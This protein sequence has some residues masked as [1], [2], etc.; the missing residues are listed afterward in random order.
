MP[1]KVT[2]PDM[3]LYDERIN[4]FVNIKGGSF[5]IEH[6]L[7]SISKWESIWHKPFFSV[8]K[9]DKKSTEELRSYIECM[10]LT[11]NVDQ[12]LYKYIPSSELDRIKAYLEDP[13]T[14]TWFRERP[15]SGRG[16]RQ[17]V[18]SEIIYYWMVALQIPFE[19]EKWHINRLLTLVRVCN[20]KNQPDKKMSKSAIMQRNTAL[21]AARRAALHTKG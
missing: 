12:T 13:M 1:L 18:T 7:I 16:P 19:C 10:T 14:A 5:K 21:N 20:E 11:P 4:E 17:I 15:G 9:K 3:E 6:S 8:D 2:V